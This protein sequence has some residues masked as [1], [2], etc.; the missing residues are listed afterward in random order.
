MFKNTVD[1]KTLILSCDMGGGHNSAAKALAQW[2]ESHG[3]ECEIADTLSFIST[4]FSKTMSDLY[5]FTT[6]SNLI[7]IIYRTGEMVPRSRKVKSPVY[8]ANKIY[9]KKLYDHI[10]EGGFDSVICTHVFPA[11]AMTVLRRRGLLPG[12]R[13]VFVQTD[14]DALPLMKDLEVDGIVI[15]H[16][17][18]IEECV[19]TGARRELL[20]PFGIPVRKE[21][22]IRVDKADAR[23]ECSGIF[24]DSGSINK[25]AHWY[26]IMSGS[27][28]FGK[29]GE[30]IHDIVDSEGKGVEVFAVC[31]SNTKLRDRLHKDFS[32][33]ANIHPIGFT[34][35][36]PLLMD[37]CDVLFTKP[38][39]LSSTEAA[40]KRIPLIHTA[41]IPGCETDNARFFHYHGMSYST[42]DTMQQVA[43]ARL[44]CTDKKF[45][46]G[47]T[48]AQAANTFPDTSEQIFNLLR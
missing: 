13:T 27:M 43:V 32:A 10:T 44:L 16:P 36:V 7:K 28:G 30:L 5:I 31:G 42:T 46:E 47:M 41:P 48:A 17:H 38:G 12:L 21:C 22:W 25:D 45:R 34:D 6:K 40:A 2:G 11:E 14:Y 8:V 15:P 37:A 33:D 9:C 26:L 24:S 29:T 39:G 19:A 20:Y 4:D 35:L 1:M 3:A 18:L 23:E